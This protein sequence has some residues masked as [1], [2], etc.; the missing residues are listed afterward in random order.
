MVNAMKSPRRN[1]W[2]REA[3]KQ[4]LADFADAISAQGLHTFLGQDGVDMGL[5]TVYRSLGVLVE[6]GLVDAIQSPEGEA[7]YR[8]CA[9]GHHHHLICRNCGFTVE[10]EAPDVEKWAANEA[11][12]YGFTKP[13]HHMEVFAI[14]EN[15]STTL[16]TR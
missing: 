3:V 6:E 5:A 7:L 12:K 14:C 16:A 11:K 8:L 4:G 2:Q 15:C 13:E 1:T 9:S 10:I